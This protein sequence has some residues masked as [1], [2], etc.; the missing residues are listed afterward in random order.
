MFQENSNDDISVFT[1]VVERFIGK[2][3]VDT[4]QKTMIQT[5]SNQ[6]PR[7]LCGTKDGD[8]L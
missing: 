5:F 4:V 8:E 3:E 7:G 2:L 6:N 1:D